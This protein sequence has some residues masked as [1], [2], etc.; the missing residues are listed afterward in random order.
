MP[1]FEN[2]QVVIDTKPNR[3]VIEIRADT[4]SLTDKNK[5][6]QKRGSNAIKVTIE[7]D[8]AQSDMKRLFCDLGFANAILEM[9]LGGD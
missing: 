1:H 7:G 4:H 9:D 2:V 6:R 8:Y 3:S 5:K